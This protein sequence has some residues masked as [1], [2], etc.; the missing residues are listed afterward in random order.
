[1][2]TEFQGTE[3]DITEECDEIRELEDEL[4]DIESRRNPDPNDPINKYRST[5]TPASLRARE[6]KARR[7][8]SE[9]AI[10]LV[11]KLSSRSRR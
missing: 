3:T 5:E 8:L 10:A 7:R 11:K 1:M 4:K 2:A 6:N 9:L